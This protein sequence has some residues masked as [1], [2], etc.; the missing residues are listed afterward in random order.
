MH[1]ENLEAPWL[2]KYQVGQ[3]LMPRT[4]LTLLSTY[5]NCCVY[6]SAKSIF[7]E[8]R[9]PQHFLWRSFSLSVQSE[10]KSVIKLTT[11]QK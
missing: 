8:V 10:C 7:S 2:F 1:S 5:S 4:I 3:G 9:M 11:V 6:Q